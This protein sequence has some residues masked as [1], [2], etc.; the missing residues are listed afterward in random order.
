MWTDENWLSD[1]VK[2]A[3][4]GAMHWSVEEAELLIG[5]PAG[6]MWQR[7]DLGQ[8]VYM[9]LASDPDCDEVLERVVTTTADEETRWQAVVIRVARAGGQGLQTLD[10]LADTTPSVRTDEMFQE[11][12]ATL[13]EHGHVPLF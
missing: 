11:M 5:A 3:V 1:E 10:R 8:C 13:V 7:G 6:D 4:V 2:H 9:L 12:R